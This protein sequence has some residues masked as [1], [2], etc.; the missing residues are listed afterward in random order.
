ME[1]KELQN[2]LTEKDYKIMWNFI[3]HRDKL[4]SSRINFLLV[5]VALSITC[6]FQTVLGDNPNIYLASIAAILGIVFCF[7]WFYVST[8]SS[9]FTS[10]DIKKNLRARFKWYNDI[11]SRRSIITGPNKLIGTYLPIMLA[12]IIILI[13]TAIWIQS[14]ELANSP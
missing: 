9:Y 6:L 12:V 2:D 10:A 4:F 7:V 11:V 8:I 3:F 5:A 14:S 1:E 13:Y